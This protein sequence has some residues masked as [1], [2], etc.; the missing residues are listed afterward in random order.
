MYHLYYVS[1]MSGWGKGLL[2][3]ITSL[4]PFLDWP[5]IISKVQLPRW[6]FQTLSLTFYP[7]PW[8]VFLSRNF[9]WN[10]KMKSRFASLQTNAR[11]ILFPQNGN[12]QSESRCTRHNIERTLLASCGGPRKINSMSLPVFLIMEL[13]YGMAKVESSKRVP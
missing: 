4:C 3:E 5:F 2:S 8:A 9:T 7:W 6:L 13:R 1:F 12:S 11:Q 10:E